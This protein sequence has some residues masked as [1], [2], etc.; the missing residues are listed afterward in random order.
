M[1]PGPSGLAFLGIGLGVLISFPTAGVASKVYIKMKAARGLD[2]F[3]E[4]R[5]PF[6]IIGSILVPVSLFWFAWSGFQR[7]HWI[8]PVLSGIP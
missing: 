1:K 8:V 6:S 7:I 2:R 4:G 3:P 5:L